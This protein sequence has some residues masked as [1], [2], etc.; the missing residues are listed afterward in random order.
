MADGVKI[1]IVSPERLLVSETAQSVTIPGSEGY[2]TVLGEHAP[3]MT[4]LKPGFITAIAAGGTQ[5]FFVR[6]GFADV[7]PDSLTILAEQAMPLSEFD[8]A[9][10]DKDLQAAEVALAAASTLE[11]KS[12]ATMQLDAWRN[13]KA[14]A[15]QIVGTAANTNRGVSDSHR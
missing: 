6:G 14:E 13:L 11:E 4:T 5:V 10:I 2:F 3:L 7:A 1:E 8:P 9:I 12:A 15:A